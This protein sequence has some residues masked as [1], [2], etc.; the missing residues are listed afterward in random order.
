MFRVQ[1]VSFANYIA[2]MVLFDALGNF[3]KSIRFNDGLENTLEYIINDGSYVKFALTK[4]KADTFSYARYGKS[5]NFTQILDNIDNSTSTGYTDSLCLYIGD[6]ISTK[7]DFQW[8]GFLTANYSF[9]DIGYAGNFRPS[10]GGKTLFPPT[11]ENTSNYSMWYLCGN[12][13]LTD[14]TPNV[15]NLFGGTND[16]IIATD[17]GLSTDTPY[18]DTDASRP[19]GLTWASAFKGCIDMLQRD[20][21]NIEIIINTVMNVNNGDDPYNATYTDGEFMARLQMEIATDYSLKCVP[22]YWNTGI[23][24]E[25]YEVYLND[26]VHPNE[27]GARRMSNVFAQTLFLK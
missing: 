21:P 5:T 8:K 9:I 15:I 1:S 26:S 2:D 19:T 25:N 16:F 17:L 27:H 23:T 4:L 20:F 24:I 7:D 12:Q 18:L 22:F 11:T 14:Y 10:L 3:I 13:R 6:S